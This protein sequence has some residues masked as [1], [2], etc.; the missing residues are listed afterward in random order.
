MTY[1]SLCETC[2][3]T[4]TSKH[5]KHAPLKPLDIVEPWGRVHLDHI[6][7]LPMTKDKF[8]HILVI[9][10]S[11][12]LWIEAFPC[13]GTTAEE[14]AKI[15]FN[16][17]I[18]RYGAM[19]QITTDGGSAFRNTLVAELCKLLRIKHAFTSA[20]HPQSNSRAERANQEI[21]KSLRLSCQ[22]QTEWA[23]RLPSILM[24]F[25][26]NIVT[27]TG[28]SPHFALFGRQMN[29][30]ID[31]ILLHDFEKAKNIQAHTTQLI[32]RLKLIHE[33]IQENLLDSN[34]V[35]KRIYDK[36]SD[37]STFELGSKCLMYMPMTRK[38]QCSKL[39]R[40]WDG[41]YIVV[42]RSDDGLLYGLRNNKTGKQLKRLVH[43]N[44]LKAY[45]DERELL[46]DTIPKQTVPSD[47]P[48]DTTQ[49]LDEGWYQIKRII[50]RRVVK[51]RE[52][53]QVEWDDSSRSWVAS[54]DVTDFAKS[55]YF[56]ALDQK[57]KS[58][59]Q[60]NRS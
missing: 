5:N 2:Q 11:T 50:K 1:V 33:N 51:G 28:V 60:K 26:A 39:L 4:K 7:P 3:R 21:I 19:R 52:W 6:G 38:G 34:V 32:P 56:I 55:T 31:L 10:D 36:K 9:I 44:R 35:N 47:V 25:R 20:H 12:T 49:N 24:S 41:P 27:S 30:G 48:N 53:F 15:L 13:R 40:R 17:V 57:R 8:K 59:R 22:D 58:R 16:E 42:S 37:L 43:V 29:L 14:V 45:R 18:T 54:K 23:E 46:H